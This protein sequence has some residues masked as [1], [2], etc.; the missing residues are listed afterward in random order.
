MWYWSGIY[1][2]M[3]LRWRLCRTTAFYHPQLCYSDLHCETKWSFQCWL[4]HNL[5][6]W[7]YSWRIPGSALCTEWKFRHRNCWSLCIWYSNKPEHDYLVWIHCWVY[8]IG[9]DTYIDF[10]LTS[11]RLSNWVE[12]SRFGWNFWDRFNSFVGII[13]DFIVRRNNWNRFWWWY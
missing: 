5:F 3:D 13:C 7:F 9:D 6:D 4:I 1:C 10:Q 8:W 2:I 12:S 11:A